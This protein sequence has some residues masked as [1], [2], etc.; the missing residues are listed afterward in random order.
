MARKKTI[1]KGRPAKARPA[2][3]PARPALKAPPPPPPTP[4]PPP[5]PPPQPPTPKP[6]AAPAA[7]GQ[8]RPATKGA[9]TV[10]GVGASAGGLEAFSEVLR[11]CRDARQLAIIFVQHLSPHHDSAL[12]PLLKVQTSLTV[13]Q[14]EERMRVE[15]GRVYV[16]PP[17]VQMEMDGTELHL[18]P[19]PADRSKHTPIDAFLVS[20]AE[21]AGERAVAVIL[22]G[23]A[24]DGAI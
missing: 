2:S 3:R 13:V 12:V 20:L 7:A 17:N 4:E 18:S 22:S 6:R 5:A 10:V 16:I 15:A 14:A 23:T 9:I 11:A 19:R 1:P 24:S 21:S 8:P